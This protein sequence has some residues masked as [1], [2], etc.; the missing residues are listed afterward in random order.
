MKRQR[1]LDIKEVSDLLGLSESTLYRLARAGRL[2]A[3][4][5]GGQWRYAYAEIIRL[6]IQR[7]SRYWRVR[8]R[9]L[10]KHPHSRPPRS[11]LLGRR[12]YEAYAKAGVF[13]RP[14]PRPDQS[15]SGTVIPKSG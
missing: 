15:G 12:I 8:E 2:P 11:T 6:S 7:W 3:Y 5:Y 14:L 13:D 9:Q 4:K 1:F 10:R